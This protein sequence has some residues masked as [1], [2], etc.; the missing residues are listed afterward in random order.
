MSGRA[1]STQT[2]VLVISG[3]VWALH[4]GAADVQVWLLD[5]LDVS[6]AP[7]VFLDALRLMV[8]DMHLYGD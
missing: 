6:A 8:R 3:S 5:N 7:P 1:A 2:R 4:H